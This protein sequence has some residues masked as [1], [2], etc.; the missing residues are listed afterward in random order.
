MTTFGAQFLRYPD[1]FPA[2]AGGE[3]WGDASFVVDLPGGPYRVN[4]LS[5]EQYAAMAERYDGYQAE[6]S[7]VA[8][9]ESELFASDSSDFLGVPHPQWEYSLELESTPAGLRVAGLD[10]MARIGF[11]SG[12]G[13]AVWTSE[14]R[15]SHFIGVI[16]NFLRVAAAHRI[17][18][19]GAALIHSSGVSVAGKCV[20]FVGHSGAGK[21][22]IASLAAARG[23]EVLSDDLNVVSRGERGWQAIRMPFAG[24][25]QSTACRNEFPLAAIV[26]LRKGP[27]HALA[28]LLQGEC[29][30]L[31]LSSAPFVNADANRVSALEDTLLRLVSD[32]P[33]WT[34]TFRRDEGL[35]PII[36]SL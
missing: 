27:D 11:D 22:T 29:F 20:L 21:S 36:E 26:R 32:V 10:F 9:F 23:H 33:A 16:E 18:A 4:G 34:L 1:L 19:S 17:A 3:R 25:F 28:P 24:D 31:L 7:I 14:G 35:W 8:S 6:P 12:T 5:P 15:Q 13:G 30:S 2:R